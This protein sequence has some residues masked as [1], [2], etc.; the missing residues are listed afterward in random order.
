MIKLASGYMM[1]GPLSRG[2]R[3]SFSALN[4]YPFLGEL[5]LKETNFGAYYNG[6][7]QATGSQHF[8]SINPADET[9]IARTLTASIA[10]YEKAISSMGQAQQEWSAL[11]MPVRG[12]IVRQIGEAFRAKK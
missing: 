1:S 9:V 11:P 3:A 6:Q 12:D 7:W 5:G 4:K 10:D 8:H 2:L